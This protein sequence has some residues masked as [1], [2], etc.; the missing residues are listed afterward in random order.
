MG[1]AQGDRAI[2]LL[3]EV[4]WACHFE[5][6]ACFLVAWVLA[7]CIF[8]AK[9]KK[10]PIE[11]WPAN[12]TKSNFRSTKKPEWNAENLSMK[13]NPQEDWDFCTSLSMSVATGVGWILKCLLISVLILLLMQVFSAPQKE[14]EDSS[15]THSEAG[16][17]D[18]SIIIK[19]GSNASDVSW[20]SLTVC[21]KYCVYVTSSTI[22]FVY[23][24]ND[25]NWL[26]AVNCLNHSFVLFLHL[27]KGIPL[28]TWT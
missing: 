9:R 15:T 17:P 22:T 3:L 8:T 2:Q 7:F 24:C 25:E 20:V 26:V 27:M 21:V 18:T 19:P 10:N 12:V 11:P 13:F 14:M 28:K 23:L 1:P 6:E 5:W 4:V 16:V